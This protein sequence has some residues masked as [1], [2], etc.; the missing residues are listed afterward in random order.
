[1]FKVMYMD[2]C[3]F[4]AIP[5]TDSTASRPP[6]PRHSGRLFQAKPATLRAHDAGRHKVTLDPFICRKERFSASNEVVHATD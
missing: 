6:I 5:A 3:V 1:M 2:L 4:H